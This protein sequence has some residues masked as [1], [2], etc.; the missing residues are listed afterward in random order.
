MKSKDIENKITK[1]TTILGTIIRTVIVMVLLVSVGLL[2]MFGIFMY[3]VKTNGLTA[4]TALYLEMPSL[5]YIL[6]DKYN[7]TEEMVASYEA[8]ISD[9]DREKMN[10]IIAKLSKVLSVGDITDEK[11]IQGKIRNALS[12]EEYEFLK[13]QIE[14]MR[15]SQIH[16]M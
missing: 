9:A 13:E 5:Q 1:G 7:I 10:G 14:L 2:L 11:T 6:N 8:D 12:D 16:I 4:V 15:G 3:Q